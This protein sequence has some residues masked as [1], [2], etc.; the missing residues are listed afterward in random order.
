MNEL[1]ASDRDLRAGHAAVVKVYAAELDGW[2]PR[3]PLHP[4]RF[5]TNKLGHP[6]SLHGVH[7]VPA[8]QTEFAT[9]LCAE[10]EGE[11]VGVEDDVVLT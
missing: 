4:G 11:H 7:S 8:Q 3:L 10:F 1:S 2:S 5:P 6:G 9:S